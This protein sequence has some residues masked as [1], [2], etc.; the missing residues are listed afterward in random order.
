MATRDD[1]VERLRAIRARPAIPFRL[2]PP[3][4][5]EEQERAQILERFSA[6]PP[7]G[8]LLAALLAQQ[9]VR[10]VAPK[11]GPLPDDLPK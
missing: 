11:N 7:R 4:P 1:I 9:T 8:N 6:N 10:R 2:T 3:D 5:A